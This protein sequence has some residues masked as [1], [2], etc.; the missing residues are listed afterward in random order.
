LERSKE[1]E[2]QYQDKEE[3][4]P[5]INKITIKGE[6]YD[7]E[8]LDRDTVMNIM[9]EDDDL[10]MRGVYSLDELE[11]FYQSRS[12]E[13]YYRVSYGGFESLWD[14]EEY[15]EYADYLNEV[16]LKDLPYTFDEKTATFIGEGV[17]A[18]SWGQVMDTTGT[19]GMAPYYVLFRGE[20][21]GDNFAGDGRVYK[22]TSV[23]KVYKNPGIIKNKK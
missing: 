21:K 11:N 18:G 7:V 9:Q 17:N 6:S 19:D 3:N 23:Y 16:V 13:A 20:Y 14:P 12:K 4:A 5:D 8:I 22:P 1:Y 2:E 10:Q 15:P